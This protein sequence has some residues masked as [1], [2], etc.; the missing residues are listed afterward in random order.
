MV[1]EPSAPAIS[2]RRTK[3]VHLG[4]DAADHFLLHCLA[5]STHS[6]WPLY[7]QTPTREAFWSMLA[8]PGIDGFT[9]AERSSDEP[10]GIV[11]AYRTDLRS[12]TTHVAIVLAEDAWQKG[13]PVEGLGLLLHHLFGRCGIRK[14]YV[15]MSEASLNRLG[16]SASRWMTKEITMPAHRRAQGDHIDVTSLSVTQDQWPYDEMARALGTGGPNQR[17][18][19]GGIR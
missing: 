8:E 17:A 14:V 19:A 2:G 18:M 3:L 16:T 4:R 15:E 13:W 7:G 11:L 6:G 12:G 5:E 10:L 1:V 9:V